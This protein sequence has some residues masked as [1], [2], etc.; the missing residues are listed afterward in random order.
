MKATT[1]AKRRA[2][3]SAFGL[4]MLDESEVE[5]IRGAEVETFELIDTVP[6]A[7]L[8][9]VALLDGVTTVEELQAVTDSIKKMALDIRQDKTLKEAHQSAA[10]RIGCKWIGGKWVVP[11]VAA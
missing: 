1:K 11:E 4:G 10:V 3:L 8:D 5:D 6:D 2:I 9:T 7:V